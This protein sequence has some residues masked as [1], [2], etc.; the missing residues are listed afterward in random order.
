MSCSR[1]LF[2]SPSQHSKNLRNV[3]REGEPFGEVETRYEALL[4]SLDM[5]VLDG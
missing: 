4:A 5:I 2:C 3:S 1:K